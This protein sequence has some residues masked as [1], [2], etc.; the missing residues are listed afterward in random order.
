MN[1]D[2]NNQE[3]TDSIFILDA[4]FVPARN[5][6]EYPSEQNR[7][8]QEQ[9]CTMVN[10]VIDTLTDTEKSV[11]IALFGLDGNKKTYS[12]VAKLKVI[13]EEMVREIEVR[14]LRKMRHPRCSHKLRNRKAY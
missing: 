7:K 6:A 11:L 10:E 5:D 13:S 8:K 14:A 2:I 9:I 4:L 3:K 1:T 12:E